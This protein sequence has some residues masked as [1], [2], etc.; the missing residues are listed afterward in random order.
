[1]CGAAGEPHDVGFPRLYAAASLKHDMLSLIMSLLSEFS[2]AL[3]RGLIEALLLQRALSCGW[4]CFPRLYAAASLKHAPGGPEAPEEGA[5][6]AALCRGL[7]EAALAL[8]L[9]PWC[10][11]GFPRLYAAA[12]LKQGHGAAAQRAAARGFPRLYAAASLKRP[13]VVVPIR[14]E[15]Q[16]FRGFMPRPH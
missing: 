8:A 4:R 11:P 2:A 6:S 16:V 15:G 10:G 3:C 5:F 9:A 13:S 12:S 7:I 1:M 14:S